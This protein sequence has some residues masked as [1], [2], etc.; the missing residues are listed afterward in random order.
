MLAFGQIVIPLAADFVAWEASVVLPHVS[1]PAPAACGFRYARLTSRHAGFNVAEAV[2]LFEARVT[3][4]A[5][6]SVKRELS[7][8]VTPAVH[9]LVNPGTYTGPTSWIAL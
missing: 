2:A 8:G 1:F 4:T 7:V 6:C 9:A 3:H 5:A